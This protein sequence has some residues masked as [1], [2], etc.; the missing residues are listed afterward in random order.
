MRFISGRTWR[1]TYF[2]AAVD[3]SMGRT[4]AFDGRPWTDALGLRGAWTAQ[5]NAA[6]KPFCAF[7]ILRRTESQWFADPWQTPLVAC[8]EPV[9]FTPRS[10]RVPPGPAQERYHRPQLSACTS[11]PVAWVRVNS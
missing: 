9:F 2:R 5:R 8:D 7:A 1:D 10:I 3:P 4:H 11:T 6:G